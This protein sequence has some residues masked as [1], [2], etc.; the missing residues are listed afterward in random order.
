MRIGK[1]AMRISA[2]RPGNAPRSESV[3]TARAKRPGRMTAFGVVL[4]A[5]AMVTTAC[6]S[7]SGDHAAAAANA[8]GVK[9]TGS[10]VKVMMMLGES[11]AL[12]NK[13]PEARHGAEARVKRINEVENGLA[14]SG[15]P[16]EIVYCKT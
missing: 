14:G 7:D 4:L 12:N 3:N 15:H 13:F 2:K 6:G 11:D 8:G 9:A 16:V 5:T 10:P 1:P